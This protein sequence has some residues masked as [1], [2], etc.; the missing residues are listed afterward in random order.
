LFALLHILDA[1]GRVT[2]LSRGVF[3][4]TGYT[5]DEL[6]GSSFRDLLH[7]DDQDTFTS[8]FQDTAASVGPFH[9]FYRFRKKDGSYIILDAVGHAHFASPSFA[10]VSGLQPPY[11]QAVFVTARPYLNKSATLLDSYLERK[12]TQE[13]LVRRILD[14][15]AEQEADSEEDNGEPM[16][17]RASRTIASPDNAFPPPA[18]D[19]HRSNGLTSTC[20]NGLAQLSEGP[21]PREN[22]VEGTV[23]EVLSHKTSGISRT[24]LI[25]SF[26]GLTCL[27]EESGC[28][29]TT[30]SAGPLLVEGDAGIQIPSKR[31]VW[32]DGDKSKLTRQEGRICA[33]CRKLN[34][35]LLERLVTNG[36]GT[37]ESPEWRKGPDG[38]KTLCNA[39][40]LRWSKHKMSNVAN[41][42]MAEGS[43]VLTSNKGD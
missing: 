25:Q 16:R 42:L 34:N 15:R 31:L 7:P 41:S 19:S 30:H 18:T 35:L 28:S 27:E 40:G 13:T 1:N 38:P 43:R 37:L 12:M 2:Y 8:E 29:T 24:D 33:N 21:S 3:V 17:S 36:L 10:Q 14:L 11:C 9:M 23:S 26:T 5:S 20:N 6:L 22:L 4:L 32:A 39:C